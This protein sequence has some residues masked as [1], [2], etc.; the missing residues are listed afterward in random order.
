V[1]RAYLALCLLAACAGSRPQP[2]SQQQQVAA[3]VEKAFVYLSN[4]DGNTLQVAVEIADTPSSRNQ[5]LMYRQS[6]ADN[7]G[8]L[9]LFP[10]ESIKTFWMKNTLIPLDMI[11]IRADMSVAGVVENAEPMTETTRSVN[12][13]SQYVLEVNGG[14]SAKNGISAGARVRFENVP[15]APP[16]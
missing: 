15:P 12:A 8:M 6:L 2:A 14:Y 4:A 1:R 13:P 10:N 5:G 16:L 9:F 3:P 11:F 7:A